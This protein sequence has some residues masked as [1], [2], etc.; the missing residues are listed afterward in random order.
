MA[1]WDA[2]NR[3]AA[4]LTN[5]GR[6]AEAISSLDRLV[7]EMEWALGKEAEELLDPL[8]TLAASFER[9]GRLDDA[10]NVMMRAMVLSEKHHG[11]EGRV[12][13]ILRSTMGELRLVSTWKRPILFQPVNR[14]LFR[15]L[16]PPTMWREG[17]ASVQRLRCSY[18]GAAM[19]AG[20][21]LLLSILPPSLCASFRKIVS[22]SRRRRW[23]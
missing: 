19:S 4:N 3:A 7:S 13:C 16:I 1:R 5:S 22:R 20:G 15:C 17:N 11:E 2:Q 21:H 14:S 6:Y 8:R 9:S 12:T 18:A 10:Y 23:L